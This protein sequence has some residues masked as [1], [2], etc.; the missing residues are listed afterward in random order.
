[1][2][3]VF[4][5]VPAYPL[6]FVVFW[7]AAAVF[8]LAMARHLRVFAAAEPVIAQPRPF[9]QVGRRL[10]GLVEY[11]LVQTKMFKDPRAAI[12]HLGIF[13]GFILLTIGTANVVTGGLILMTALVVFLA[14]PRRPV[15]AGR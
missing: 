7:G 14:G 8:A 15:P 13:W 6:V 5:D 3:P 1:M 11:A 2:F 10:A 12:L 9:G 4:A